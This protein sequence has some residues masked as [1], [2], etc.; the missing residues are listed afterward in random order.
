MRIY[1]NLQPNW[2]LYKTPNAFIVSQYS[3]IPAQ[4]II[5][6]MRIFLHFLIRICANSFSG[7]KIFVYIRN[8][9]FIRSFFSISNS[10]ICNNEI[11]LNCCRENTISTIIDMFTND[12]HSAWSSA[13]ELWLL[14]VNLL[15]FLF[16]SLISY[17]VF[18]FY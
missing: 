10:G 3:F 8:S 12:V 2:L 6:P 7:I 11:L 1:H 9:D 18:F 13:E 4:K 17:F 14:P 15:K 16:Q 5:N